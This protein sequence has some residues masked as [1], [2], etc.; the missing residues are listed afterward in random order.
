MSSSSKQASNETSER[1][2]LTMRW[3]GREKKKKKKGDEALE[4]ITI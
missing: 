1:K 4:A 2:M 3:S